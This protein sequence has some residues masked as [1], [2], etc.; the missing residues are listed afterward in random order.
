M[1]K[2]FVVS[3]W[4]FLP[5]TLGIILIIFLEFLG[6]L[7]FF[8]WIKLEKRVPLTLSKHQNI[9][10][11]TTIG[12]DVSVVGI[13]YVTSISEMSFL[14]LSYCYTFSCVGSISF[15]V[16]LERKCVGWCD[17]I[18]NLNCTINSPTLVPLSMPILLSREIQP[19]VSAKNFNVILK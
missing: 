11:S 3:T 19:I 10:A 4:N 9:F 8:S 14:Q 18:P 7:G 12:V 1:A 16:L 6:Y 15:V 2:P 13:D 5:K 17:S